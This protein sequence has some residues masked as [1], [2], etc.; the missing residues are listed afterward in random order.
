MKSTRLE[1]MNFPGNMMVA[2]ETIARNNQHGPPWAWL[3][4]HFYSRAGRSFPQLQRLNKNEVP[5][6]YDTLLVH[7][8]D[9][10]PTLER[11]YHQPINLAVLHREVEDG[12]Y[13]REVILTRAM[14]ARPVEYGVIH[15]CLPFFPPPAQLQILGEKQPLG[16][17]LR[18]N[19]IGHLAWPQAF[20]QARSDA[21]MKVVLELSQLGPLYGR[22]NVLLDGSRRMLAEVIEVLAPVPGETDGFH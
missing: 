12:H 10:T 2:T 6:P 21:H 1:F 22:R 15:M 8:S 7:N 18:Q 9:M 16:A 5:P 4:D 17:I 19:A 3:L 13:Y 14:D 20:F 11:F